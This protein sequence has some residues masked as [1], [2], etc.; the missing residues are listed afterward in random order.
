MARRT[1]LHRSR[2]AYLSCRAHT[3]G[4]A[5]V[6]PCRGVGR[7]DRSSRAISGVRCVAPR[8]TK[9]LK[10]DFE[11]PPISSLFLGVG[12]VPP[13]PGPLSKHRLLVFGACVF[14]KIM[15]AVRCNH[16]HATV[17]QHQDTLSPFMAATTRKGPALIPKAVSGT[18]HP[19]HARTWSGGPVSS[20]GSLAGGSVDSA[21]VRNTSVRV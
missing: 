19:G 18:P 15:T 13:R 10:S 3:P 17:T 20:I 2:V 8:V 14:L 1:G 5:S 7:M 11:V 16:T 12:V 4:T 21:P 9:P 6:C